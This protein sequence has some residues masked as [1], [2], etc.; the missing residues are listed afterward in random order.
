MMVACSSEDTALKNTP[1]AGPQMQFTATIAAPNSGATTRT[2]YT[3][4]TT[5]DAAGTINVAWKVNDEI[6]AIV[7]NSEDKLVKTVLTVSKVNDDGSAVISGAITKPKN[8]EETVDL[9]YPADIVTVDNNGSDYNISFDKMSD[10]TLDGTLESIADNIDY[11]TAD[12]CELTVSGEQA[13][14]TSVAKL[15]SKLSILKLTLQDKDGNALLA[16]QVAIAGG[17]ILTSA[18]L[19]SDGSSEVY[20]PVPAVS[21]ADICIAATTSSNNYFYMKEDV[22][23]AAK[24]YYQSTVKMTKGAHL[25]LLLTDEYEAKDGEILT[26]T[27]ASNVKISI[28]A[29]VAPAT[30]TTVTLKDVNINGSGTWTTGDY[31]G[32]TCDGSTTIILEGEN[33]VKGFWEDY[34]GIYVPSGETLIIQ[35][36]GSLDASSNSS[37]SLGAGIGSGSGGTCG[38]ITIKGGTVT[39]TGGY[40]AAGIGSGSYGTCENITISGGKVTATGG[41]YGAGIG[42]GN[43]GTCGAIT[44]SSGTVT[45]TGGYYAAGIGSGGGANCGTITIS[46]GTVT[47][48]GDANGAGIGS[49]GVVDEIRARCGAITITAGV[50]KVTAKKGA[51]A[52]NSIG[53]GS[54]GYCGTVTIGGTEYASGVTQSPYEYSAPPALS[55]TSPAVGQVIGSDGKNY[56]A[57][58]TLPTGVTKVAM[59][60]YLNGSHGLAIAL[61][62]EGEMNWATAKSTCEAKTSAFNNGTW[63]LPT[64]DDWKKMFYAT[65][66]LRDTIWRYL[67]D[68]LE[69]AGGV[70]SRLRDAEQYWSSTPNGEDQANSVHLRSSATWN[71]SSKT[72]TFFV[73]AV[74]AF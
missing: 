53:A 54:E 20:L 35:G 29:P 12:D 67:A 13:T 49:G 56:A 14:L 59:I 25:A 39:A 68:E 3:E 52:P 2:E 72:Y 57:D 46:G 7:K 37:S 18:T 10:G 51:T 64:Q 45:A 6:A 70:G 28:A 26:G 61:A 5:G 60:A 34:P 19:T 24:Q 50:T 16:S 27:L 63:R 17:K 65:S 66:R 22:T 11:R 42:G 30:T 71:S 23:L 33:K 41:K 55:L 1:A 40:N 73:R 32:I 21:G 4:V 43:R 44:I 47:A 15:E 48:T 9:I 69:T 38:N 74:L 36:T 58:A 8:G 62:D 31:A